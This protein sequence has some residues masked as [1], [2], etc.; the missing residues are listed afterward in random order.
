MTFIFKG[1]RYHHTRTIWR[2]KKT[3]QIVGKHV[4]T[5]APIIAFEPFITWEGAPV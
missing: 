2:F 1:E 5:G 3:R 4:T